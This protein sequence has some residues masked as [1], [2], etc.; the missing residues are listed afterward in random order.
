MHV[1]YTLALIVPKCSIYVYYIMNFV[2]LEN[3]ME[4]SYPLRLQPLCLGVLWIPIFLK[5]VKSQYVS[6][7]PQKSILKTSPQYS[8]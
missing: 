8:K 3:G 1:T 4:L 7:P 2:Y 6:F 5:P